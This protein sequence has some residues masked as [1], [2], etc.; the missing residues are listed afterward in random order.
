MKTSRSAIS[1]ALASSPSNQTT[2]KPGPQRALERLGRQRRGG[3]EQLAHAVEVMG[4][5]P[6]GEVASAARPGAP[7]ISRPAGGWKWMPFGASSSIGG[8]AANALGGTP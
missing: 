5:E 2:T 6:L 7:G 1:A 3:L 4:D 8:R